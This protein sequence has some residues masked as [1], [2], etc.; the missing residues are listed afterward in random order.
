MKSRDLEKHLKAHGCHFDHHGGRHDIWRNP[1]NGKQS[2][3]PRGREIVIY[4][5]E[6]ICKDLDIP[7]P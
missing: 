6:N 1:E 7:K 2:A 3:V 5:A 4:T